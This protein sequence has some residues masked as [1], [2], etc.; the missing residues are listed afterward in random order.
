M[1]NPVEQKEMIHELK[2]DLQT[3]KC[4]LSMKAIKFSKFSQKE[5]PKENEKPEIISVFSF[6]TTIKRT[7]KGR[8]HIM[9]TIVHSTVKQIRA[10]LLA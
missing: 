9:A 6:V 8:R 1:H 4:L 5:E 7:A 3:E 10:A 2:N